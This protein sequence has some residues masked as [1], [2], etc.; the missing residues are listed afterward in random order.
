MF[1]IR[2]RR[3]KISVWG[4]PNFLRRRRHG[5]RIRFRTDSY[6]IWNR[7]DFCRF[8]KYEHVRCFVYMKRVRTGNCFC[9]HVFRHI[10]KGQCYDIRTTHGRGCLSRW[11][12]PNAVVQIVPEREE[13]GR[14]VR[15]FV[16][17]RIV[18]IDPIVARCVSTLNSKLYT[19]VP[20]VGRFVY[21]RFRG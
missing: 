3:R 2:T 16:L 12:H 4:T 20:V 1:H 9:C 15:V 7:P 21:A 17:T 5:V 10:R 6:R 14:F 8:F 13:L 11:F 19:H 18:N